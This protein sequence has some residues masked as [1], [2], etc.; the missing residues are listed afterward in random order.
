MI[1][2]TQ[3]DQGM[4]NNFFYR[5]IRHFERLNTKK[6]IY[7][8]KWHKRFPQY[9]VLNQAAG[10]NAYTSASGFFFFLDKRRHSALRHLPLRS[11]ESL[12]VVTIPSSHQRAL[13]FQSQQ[14]YSI[15]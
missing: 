14:Q 6:N 8:Q 5:Q 10:D 13:L 3:Q 15:N 2:N 1:Y 11:V 12:L 9:R 4:N 7:L